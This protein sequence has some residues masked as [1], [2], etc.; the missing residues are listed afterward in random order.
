MNMELGK[1]DSFKKNTESSPVLIEADTYEFRKGD[2]VSV[3]RSGDGTVENDW[4]LMSAGGELAV[5]EKTTKEG[6]H[7]RKLIPI[8]EFKKLQIQEKEGTRREFSIVIGK[9]EAQAIAITLEHMYSTRPLTHELFINTLG[10]FDIKLQHVVI[11]HLI[12]GI[13]YAKLSCILPGQTSDKV[14]EIDSRTSDAIALAARVGCDIYVTAEVLDEVGVVDVK[15]PVATVP[16]GEFANFSLKQLEDAM[17]KATVK[18]D[19]AKAI[20]IREEI[21]RRK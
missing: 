5:V 12:D 17:G 1:R 14:V 11:N 2:K 10:S 18:E 6:E 13:F 15:A 20:K 19:Y 16:V 21:K 3:V 7:L 8:N 4:M 9:S